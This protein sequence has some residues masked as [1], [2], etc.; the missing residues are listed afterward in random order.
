MSGRRAGS[1]HKAESGGREGSAHQAVARKITITMKR[2][3]N[4]CEEESRKDKPPNECTYEITKKE[5][6][7]LGKIHTIKV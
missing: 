2:R 6:R 3:K 5:N 4:D 7:W 1:K